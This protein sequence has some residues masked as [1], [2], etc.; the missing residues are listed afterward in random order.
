MENIN[1][2]C[3]EFSRMAE[4]ILHQMLLNLIIPNRVALYKIIIFIINMELS[5]DTSNSIT[6]IRDGETGRTLWFNGCFDMLSQYLTLP[7]YHLIICQ[8]KKRSWNWW[9]SPG[10]TGVRIAKE[11]KV[12]SS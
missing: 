4:L 3:L 5:T 2:N 12:R 10:V 11:I 9:W 1:G 8:I 7:C 6:M